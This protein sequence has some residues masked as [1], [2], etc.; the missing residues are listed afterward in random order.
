MTPQP[1]STSTPT[2]SPPPVEALVPLP[3][4]FQSQGPLGV[5]WG[6]EAFGAQ[7]VAAT[8]E[9][10]PFLV[11]R[12]FGF[13]RGLYIVNARTGQTLFE[14]PTDAE[15]YYEDDSFASSLYVLTYDDGDPSILIQSWDLRSG[16][17]LWEETIN[18]SVTPNEIVAFKEGV[19]LIGHQYG[20]GPNNTFIFLAGCRKSGIKVGRSKHNQWFKADNQSAIRVKRDKKARFDS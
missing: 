3:A 20:P 7:Y 11:Y 15:K 13:N 19:L 1:S 5:N 6:I 10:P 16:E 12:R 4:L 8:G 2:S 9:G 14:L 17:R 18:Q